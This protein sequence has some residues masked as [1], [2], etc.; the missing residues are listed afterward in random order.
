[1]LH[2]VGQKAGVLAAAVVM[3]VIKHRVG[4]RCLPEQA[5]KTGYVAAAAQRLVGEARLG[6]H[7]LHLGDV[8]FLAVVTGAHQG[9]LL[10]RKTKLLGA[11]RLHEGQRL[12]GL[13]G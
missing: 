11:L 1:V 9:D 6:Q 7:A 3:P 4:R 2:A 12:Q 5:V 13:E 10:W 8:C